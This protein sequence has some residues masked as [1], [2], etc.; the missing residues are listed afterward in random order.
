MKIGLCTI[1]NKE[2]SLEAVLAQAATA[3][4]DGIEVWGKD[5]V[6]DGTDAT[7]RRI[8]DAAA[9]HD[10]SI[11]TYGAYLRAGAESF[12]EDLVHEVAVADRLEADRIRVWA[13]TVEYGDHDEA[14]WEQTVA[15]LRELTALADSRGVDV[16]V[17]K[18]PGYLTNEAEGARRLIES[19]DDPACGLNYQPMFSLSPQN[20]RREIEQLAP[21]S[22]QLHLQAVPEMGA[23]GHDRCALAD[24]F[25]D[26][27][28]VVDQFREHG[29][30]D[31]SIHV[32]FVADDLP[33]SNAIRRDY[34]YLKSLLE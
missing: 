2:A 19:V 7:C 8:R 15:D 9:S 4:Y 12:S 31:S 22:N 28:Y 14:Q 5:H 30:S 29:A 10:L 25:Y 6:G 17:E 26:V 18:H 16:T 33:Y 20:I 13:G 34:E 32:E 3:G 27:E 21:L 11:L 23:N 1:S 24:A